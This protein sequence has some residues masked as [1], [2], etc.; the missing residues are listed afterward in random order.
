MKGNL[1]CRAAAKKYVARKNGMMQKQDAIHK[2]DPPPTA[3]TLPSTV[4]PVRRA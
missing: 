3:H 1:F 4:L 2:M